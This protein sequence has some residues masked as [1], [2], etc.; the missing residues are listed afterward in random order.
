MIT[1]FRPSAMMFAYVRRRLISVRSKLVAARTMT[2]QQGLRKLPPDLI[3]KARDDT[4]TQVTRIGLTLLGTAAFCLLSLLTP[5]SA[6]LGGSEKI[7]VPFAGPVSF[8]GFMLLGPA[9]LIVLR[10]YLQIY[11]EHGDRLDR[12]AQ[13]VSAMRAPTL[14][15]LQNPLVR[16]LSGL[17]FYLLLPVTILL[18]AWKAAVFPAWASALLTLAVAVI[19]SQ[20]PCYR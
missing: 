1:F 3:S 13:S 17:V 2:R 19:A 20:T 5:D 16:L 14:V 4:A 15:L 11:V 12:L 7:N 10:V 6:L 18:F 9:V 8:F